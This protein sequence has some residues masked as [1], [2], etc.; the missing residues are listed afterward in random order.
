MDEITWEPQSVADLASALSR[1]GNDYRTA[2]ADLYNSFN[3]LGTEQ[4]WVGRNF[5]VVANEV[6]NNAIGKFENWSNYLQVTIPQTVAD[7]AEAQAE[8]GGGSVGF[9]LTPNSTEIKRIQETVEKADG[10]QILDTEVVRNEINNNLPSNSEFA[11]ARLQDYYA[12]FEE[13]GTLDG[14]AAI[15][16]MYHE[17][18]SILDGCRRILQEFQDTAQ[19]TVE[20]SV[21]RTELTN[22]EAREIAGRISTLVG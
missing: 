9:S 1:I 6:L 20:K 18:D 7:I 21:Q 16:D 22:E 11:M 3:N 13:L 14:N 4:K 17:L 12:Q 5:N 10:S 2:I 19:N 8:V 15:L